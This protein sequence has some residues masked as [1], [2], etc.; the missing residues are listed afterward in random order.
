[1]SFAIERKEGLFE[2]SYAAGKMIANV[3][4]KV[5]IYNFITGASVTD[6]VLAYTVH[7]S[8][9]LLIEA[10]ILIIVTYAVLGVCLLCHYNLSVAIPVYEF[11]LK[12]SEIFFFLVYLLG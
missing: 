12:E 1:M 4:E 8:M 6:F 2:R 9:I 3:N 11:R 5:I 7:G 10:I